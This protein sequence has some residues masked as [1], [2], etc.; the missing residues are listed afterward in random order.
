MT[1]DN[2]R[3][4]GDT[5]VDVASRLDLREP[6]RQALET[7][8]VEM[9]RHYDVRGQGRPFEGVVVSAT[10]VGK[11]YVLASAIEYLAIANG[12][13][14]F[15]V[16]TPGRTILDKTLRNFTLG[17][18]K[19][20]L[21]PMSVRPLVVTAENFASPAV[22]ADMENPERVKLYVFTVQSLIRPDTQMGRRTHKFQEG[23]GAALYERLQDAEDL[24]VFADEHHC[25]YGPAF[26]RAIRDLHPY[27]LIGL[28]ATPH[29]RTPPEQIIFRYPLAAAIADRLVKTPVVV[30]R[31]DDRTDPLTKLTDG[32][33]LLEF[34]QQAM[35][36]WSNQTGETPVRPVMLVVA[37]GIPE[38]EEYGNILRSPEFFGGRYADAVLVVHSDSP[39][40]ALA[41][42]DSVEDAASPVRIILSV[43]ML[44]EGWD[45]KNV[46]VIASMRAS[47]S[48][49]LTEQTLGRGLRLPFG[50]YTDVELLDTLEVVAHERY[51]DLLRQAGAIREA[52]V[53]YRVRSVLRTT[54]EGRQIGGREQVPVVAPASQ[55]T[56]VTMGGAVDGPVGGV[57]TGGGTPTGAL[58]LPVMAMDDRARTGQAQ[59]QPELLRPRADMPPI[60]IPRLRMHSV[61]VQFSFQDITD[62]EPFRRL[63]RALAANPEE[64]LRRTLVRA[65]VVQGLDGLRYTQIVTDTAT[66]KLVSQ[67]LILPLPELVQKLVDS[68]L[69]AS[70][71]PARPG[72][73]AAVQPIIDA[74]QQGLGDVA[75]A[76]LSAY[77]DRVAGKLVELVT[78]AQR[79]FTPP[80]VYETVVDVTE[81]ASTRTPRQTV[82]QDR[83]GPFVRGAGYVGWRRSLYEQAWF[84]SHPERDMAL[85]LDDTDEVACWVRLHRNDLPILWN[86]HDQWYNPDFIVVE[87]DGSHWVLE[88]KADREMESPDVQGKKEAA[89]R[90]ANHVSTDETVGARW[91]YILA[92]ESD[93]AAARGSW[94]ALKQLA[95]L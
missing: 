92:K 40:E 72:Q 14:N 37:Q 94:S 35:D 8:A 11:T 60:R 65:Q 91:G 79:R 64:E 21:N 61:R 16:I 69:N 66:D 19:S 6:N 55:D 20:L 78:E 80:P 36:A 38:A 24:V 17:D 49:I 88:V 77:F 41:K 82:L 93:V 90:W 18:P 50:A 43:G 87:R 70:I 42:L 76:V 73:R 7:I 39:D 3:V 25:Y 95:T 27:A 68:L 84:D 75:Q 63:G 44:K 13:R 52:L 59:A 81:F 57:M 28:T 56:R 4:D 23:L 9:S 22:R 86:G 26:S 2:V 1:E 5:L 32:A 48:D 54:P 29:P 51:V 71:V 53:D 33:R 83:T 46:Y 85:I 34:K 47:V 10:G 74:L 45:V 12:I 89:R 30:G 67:G 58:L 31:H 15:A 62:L